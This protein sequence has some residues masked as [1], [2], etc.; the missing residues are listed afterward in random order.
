[1]EK[2]CTVREGEKKKKKERE[3]KIFRGRIKD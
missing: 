1:M 2:E 3:G